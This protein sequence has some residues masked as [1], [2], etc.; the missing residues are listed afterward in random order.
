MGWPGALMDRSRGKAQG[1][2]HAHVPASTGA[3][4]H[5]HT[6]M[7]TRTCRHKRMR[8]YSRTGRSPRSKAC[9]RTERIQELG[10]NTPSAHRPPLRVA[11]GAEWG[12]PIRILEAGALVSH[13][14]EN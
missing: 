1:C 4:V 6:R 7:H 8:T 2:V 10:S 3:H 11:L 13:K 14:F 9:V 5:A 12:K